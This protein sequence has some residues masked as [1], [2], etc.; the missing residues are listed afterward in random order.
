MPWA[1]TRLRRS[2]LKKPKPRPATSV[3]PCMKKPNSAATPATR[4][5]MIAR[6]TRAPMVVHRPSMR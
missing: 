5:S 6:R 4:A 3:P 2:E 1:F